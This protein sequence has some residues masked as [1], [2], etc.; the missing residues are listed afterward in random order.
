MLLNKTS[1]FE[2]CID[3]LRDFWASKVEVNSE[4]SVFVDSMHDN[5]DYIF[6][7]YHIAKIL[8]SMH[9]CRLVSA[10]KNWDTPL[11]KYSSAVNEQI[12]YGFG[13]EKFFNLD[14][15]GETKN[16]KFMLL[17]EEFEKSFVE[18]NMTLRSWIFDN[19]DNYILEHKQ[20][21]R[22]AYDHHLRSTLK[23]TEEEFSSEFSQCLLSCL[24]FSHLA[25]KLVSSESVKVAVL[26]HVEYSPYYFIAEEVIKNGGTVLFHWPLVFGSVRI[27]RK[28]E[29]LYTLKSADFQNEYKSDYLTKLSS[30]DSAIK[31]YS[32]GLVDR[33]TK[34]R[35]YGNFNQYREELTR[36]QF[37]NAASV[38]K[39][40]DKTII[41]LS[42]ALTDA[43]HGNGEMLFDDFA[44]W[45]DETIEYFKEHEQFNILVKVH[46]KDVTY[47]KDSWI[48]KLGTKYGDVSNFGIV[49][50]HIN[51]R[52][53]AKFCDVV[54]TVQGTPGYELPLIGIKTVI[55]GEA[56]YSRLGICPHCN[57]KNEYFQELESACN[58][59]NLEGTI[60]QNAVNFAFYE[61]V[62]TKLSTNFIPNIAQFKVDT[63]SWKV[64]SSN[65]SNNLLTLDPV[66]V[67][68]SRVDLFDCNQPSFLKNPLFI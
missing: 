48:A 4:W 38:S 9:G 32:H 56:R 13:A 34:S 41:L 21:L 43:V 25:R 39:P 8:Q 2:E 53:V 42:H 46:P 24:A 55:A 65:F 3:T 31:E 51:N 5:M 19:E 63:P 50:K 47:V 67:A 23:P 28:L 57:S 6:F 27:F 54:S 29:D 49:S 68:L 30:I 66:Y 35:D 16:Q 18:S 15:L 36:E 58:S 44:V 17:L 11:I 1:Q 7:N 40:R 22:I 52:E 37:F 12:A 45:I 61:N 26:G 14:S 60:V 59:P 33:L 64:L 10:S 62:Y 20:L